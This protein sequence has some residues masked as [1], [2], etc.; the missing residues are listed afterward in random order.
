MK[1]STKGIYALEAAL[2]LAVHT[3]EGQTESIKNIAKR[4]G[5]SEKYLERIIGCLKKAGIVESFRGAAGGYCLKKKPEE[6]TALQIL[7]A[8][9]GDMAPVECL[10]HP[11]DCGMLKEGCVTRGTWESMWEQ[12]L[13]TASSVSL[14]DLI[15]YMEKNS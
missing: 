1:I 11:V 3:Q 7:E 13:L 5:L 9:E 15:D 8:A 4:R 2:D 12:L 6:I 10:K 14:R